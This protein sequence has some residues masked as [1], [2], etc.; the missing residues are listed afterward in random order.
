MADGRRIISH[1]ARA[2][3]RRSYPS[4]P[5][6]DISCRRD[7]NFLSPGDINS[8]GATATPRA[9]HTSTRPPRPTRQLIHLYASRLSHFDVSLGSPPSPVCAAAPVDFAHEVAAD[10]PRPLRQVPHHLAATKA[11]SRWTRARR[12]WKRRCSNPAPAADSELIRRVTSDDPDVRMP[13][14]GPA[15]TVAE[16]DI[17]RRWIDEGAA[18]EPGFTFKKSAYEAPLAPRR[19]DLPPAAAAGVTNPIDRIVSSLLART[20]HHA[21]GPGKRRRLLPPRPSRPRRP[22]PRR[23]ATSKP[24]SPIEAPTSAPP[25]EAPAG[26]PRRLRRPLAHLLERPAPQRLRRHRLHRRRPQADHRLA[27]PVRSSTTCP[28]TSSSASS[29]RRRPTPPVSPKASS[30]AA[31][32]TPANGPPLQFAQNV[33]QVFLGIN[34]KCASCHDSFIDHWKL[35][36]AYGL[37]AIASDEPLELHRCDKPT[38]EMAEARFLFPR[39]GEIDAIAPRDERL[40]A[41]RRPHDA[42]A[43]RPLH[44]HDRQ[45]PLASPHGP[46]HRPPGRLD[47]HGPLECRP[48][49]RARRR[50]GRQRLRPEANA[51]ADR[52]LP[53]L[54]RANRPPG[55][56]RRPS[57]TTS[58]P[59]PRPSE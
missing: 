24:S 43:K 42:P 34:L 16:V 18:W 46:R 58:S 20:Q 45:P 8:R 41:T 25:G 10:H 31:T 47:G 19:P 50:S 52:H 14:K 13:P 38:G 12:C 27:L 53:G 4:G 40:R 37:A 2:C 9:D 57:R 23:R 54:R 55:T 33:G 29:S 26:R 28:T 17:L 56:K 44:A 59:A 32:S 35:N 39:L 51:R 49:R 6:A 21:A 7:V 30:G 5:W 1:R 48:A 15:L 3:P 11:T 22:A 36:D